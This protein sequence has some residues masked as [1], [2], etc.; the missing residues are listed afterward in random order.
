MTKKVRAER[1]NA[2]IATIAGC[3]RKFF[4]HEG[5][6]SRF[7]VDRRGRIWFIDAWRESKIYTHHSGRW[8]G[9]SEGGTL[10][11][12]VEKLRDF[13]STGN[14]QNLHLGPWPEYVCEGDLW[15]YKDDMEGVRVAAQTSGIMPSNEPVE[16]RALARPA[17]TQS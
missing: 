8:R 16:G 4:S 7:E 6:I 10:R 3:G 12:L 13:I 2:F 1:A 5:R 15:G 11:H 14:P 17:R 9:F